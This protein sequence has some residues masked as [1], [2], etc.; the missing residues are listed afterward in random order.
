MQLHF[1]SAG[2]NSRTSVTNLADFQL[3][4]LYSLH[5]PILINT[6]CTLTISLCFEIFIATK[7]KGIQQLQ[8]FTDTLDLQKLPFPK[9]FITLRF[10]CISCKVGG[11]R[12]QLVREWVLKGVSTVVCV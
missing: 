3:T 8:S 12:C 5:F 2:I 11:A 7:K 4:W 10:Y 6:S 9:G 1:S